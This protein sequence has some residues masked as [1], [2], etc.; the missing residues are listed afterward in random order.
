MTYKHRSVAI[1]STVEYMLNFEQCIFYLSC[2]KNKLLWRKLTGVLKIGEIDSKMSYVFECYNRENEQ[3]NIYVYKQT[4]KVE[5][6]TNR[7]EEETKNWL[8]IVKVVLYVRI[9]KCY[10][11]DAKDGE[12]IIDTKDSKMLLSKRNCTKPDNVWSS[13]REG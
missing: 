9:C 3:T 4:W 1:T 2:A 13:K 10:G 5:L 12:T 8:V 6:W 7:K 11:S